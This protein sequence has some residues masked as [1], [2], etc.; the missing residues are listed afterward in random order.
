MY[1]VHL[2]SFRLKTGQMCEQCFLL[3][4]LRKVVN[5]VLHVVSVGYFGLSELC[6]TVLLLGLL[7]CLEC[8]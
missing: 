4:V 5:Q 3:L 7:R 2:H 1:G 8:L 6:S